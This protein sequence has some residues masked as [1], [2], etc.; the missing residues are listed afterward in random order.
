M[1]LGEAPG[2]GP[3]GKPGEAPGRGSWRR[4]L[5]GGPQG[6]PMGDAPGGGPWGRPLGEAPGDQIQALFR[7]DNL[8]CVFNIH[9][10]PAFSV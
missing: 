7:P 3:W 4:P 6:R 5:G 10:Y 9:K 8:L 2:G 1:P